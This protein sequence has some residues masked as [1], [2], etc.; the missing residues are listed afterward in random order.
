MMSKISRGSLEKSFIGA[1]TEKIDRRPV[2]KVR[3][4]GVEGQNRPE[5]PVITKKKEEA[6]GH[7]PLHQLFQ[8]DKTVI[9]GT[10]KTVV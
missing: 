7:P 10:A 1:M 3:H 9:Q 6:P 8:I 5:I 4:Q 2:R